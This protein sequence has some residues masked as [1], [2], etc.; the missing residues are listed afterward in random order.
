MAT[1]KRHRKMKR[2][3][4]SKKAF[5]ALMKKGREKAMLKRSRR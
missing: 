4:L 5:L 3:H 2:K 1:R